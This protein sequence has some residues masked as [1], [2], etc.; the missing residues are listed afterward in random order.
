MATDMTGFN[1]DNRAFFSPQAGLV[2]TQADTAASTDTATAAMQQGAAQAQAD[3]AAEKQAQAQAAAQQQA[4]AAAAAQQQAQ[5]QAAAVQQARAVSAAQNVA[6]GLQQG[7][8]GGVPGAPVTMAEQTLAHRY[9]KGLLGA[10]QNYMDAQAAGN[11]AGMQAAHEQAEVIRRDAKAHGVDLDRDYGADRTF[12]EKQAALADDANDMYSRLVASGTSS[13]QYYRQLYDKGLSVGMSPAQ[14]DTYAAGKAAAYQTQR[15]ADLRAAFYQYGLDGRNAITQDGAML[16]NQMYDEDPASIMYSSLNF[17]S[18]ITEYR[19]MVGEESA[20][21]ALGRTLKYG[22][23]QHGWDIGT[24]REKGEQARLGLQT[25]GNEQRE[26]LKTKGAVQ[27]DVN[28]SATNDQIRANNNAAQNRVFV[29]EH[30]PRPVQGGGSGGSGGGGTNK[31]SKTDEERAN[32]WQT[33]YDA[34]VQAT[35]GDPLEA[36]D[37]L[38]DMTDMLND[39]T[40]KGYF[41]SAEAQMWFGRIKDIADRLEPLVKKAKAEQE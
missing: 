29:M 34:L 35:E 24:I 8:M 36:W 19:R 25:E 39:Y 22:D 21:N 27:K 37:K 15:L 40:D 5:A 3:H 41:T 1:W 30:T 28:E 20:D 10:T 18:P 4:Q 9:K 2:P 11:A 14:A 7:L 33:K 32:A 31:L 17:A 13:G 26:T 12:A 6:A 16:L 38:G 23:T